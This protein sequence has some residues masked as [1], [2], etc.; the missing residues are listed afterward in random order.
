MQSTFFTA[1]SITLHNTT[2]WV[3]TF[4]MFMCLVL[5]LFFFSWW[6]EFW[7]YAIAHFSFSKSLEF[8]NIVSCFKHLFTRLHFR[9]GQSSSL[10]MCAI[11]FS[12]SLL[13]ISQTN[14]R[15][16]AVWSPWVHTHSS[17]SIILKRCALFCHL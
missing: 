8:A 3:C 15:W 2:C 11:S 16:S 14:M 9:T 13:I 5:V 17:D 1:C 10:D 7:T 4:N 12:F 6:F